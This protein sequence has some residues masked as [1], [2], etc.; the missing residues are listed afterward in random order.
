MV[1]F[2]N[3]SERIEKMRARLI[4]TNTGTCRRIRLIWNNVKAE[5]TGSSVLPSDRILRNG[6]VIQQMSNFRM[7]YG[8]KCLKEL[9]PLRSP[10]QLTTLRG[11]IQN[12][13]SVAIICVDLSYRES[14]HATKQGIDTLL[15]LIG[16][17]HT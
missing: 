4:D 16:W 11:K 2:G 3:S 5:S 7:T 13:P 1:V 12:Q 17:K 9:L 6:M 14:C 10:T 15:T 8:R